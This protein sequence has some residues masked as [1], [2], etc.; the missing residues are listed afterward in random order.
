MAMMKIGVIKEYVIKHL[1]IQKYLVLI[2]G[3]HLLIIILETMRIL[4]SILDCYQKVIMTGFWGYI[5]EIK[6]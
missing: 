1:V 4:L 6:K 2:G 5:I 3:I